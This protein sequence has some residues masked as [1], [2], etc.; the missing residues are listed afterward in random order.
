M[1]YMSPK[2]NLRPD[3]LYRP[4]LESVFVDKAKLVFL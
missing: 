1:N 2:Y 3:A 4:Q